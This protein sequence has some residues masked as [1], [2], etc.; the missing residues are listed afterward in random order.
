ME[1]VCVKCDESKQKSDYHRCSRDKRG[2]QQPCAK[3][4]NI[5]KKEYKKTPKGIEVNRKSGRRWRKNHKTKW[6]AY[7]REHYRNNPHMKKAYKTLHAAQ[8]KDLITPN[9]CE[10]CGSVDVHGHHE[11]YSK[12]LEVNWLCALHHREAH[13]D[14][15]MGKRN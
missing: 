13:R 9:P 14:G 11:D 12:P 2:Y 6:N 5:I 8:E 4:R 1:I 3:C 7:K 15:R 10:I